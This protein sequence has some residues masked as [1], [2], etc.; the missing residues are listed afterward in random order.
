MIVK[1]HKKDEKTIMAVCDSDL[2]GRI[3]EDNEL[4]LDLS[5]DFYKG[6]Q[7][8]EKEVGDLIRNSDSVNLVGEKSIQIGLNEGIIEKKDVKFIQKI[9]YAQVTI[10]HE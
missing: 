9:P 10:L 1:I 5:S 7:K 4:Q 6:E 2:I 3:F 8:N